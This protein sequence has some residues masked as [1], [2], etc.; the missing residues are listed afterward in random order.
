MIM[1]KKVM[2]PIMMVTLSLFVI[3]CG[4]S[5]KSGCYYGM[6]ENVQEQTM[7]TEYSNT[8]YTKRAKAID[9]SS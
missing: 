3:S 1:K 9:T 8:S 7:E 2:Y 4:S 6:E 5:Q